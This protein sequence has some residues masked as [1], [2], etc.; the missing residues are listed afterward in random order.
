[1]LEVVVSEVTVGDSEQPAQRL[2]PERLGTRRPILKC[3]LALSEDGLVWKFLVGNCP[4][5][6]VIEVRQS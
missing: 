5:P 3:A 6:E 4:L 2:G 1:M